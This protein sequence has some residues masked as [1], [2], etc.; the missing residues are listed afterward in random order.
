MSGPPSGL[1]PRRTTSPA[2]GHPV[3]AAAPREGDDATLI[4]DEGCIAH[5]AICH[6]IKVVDVSIDDGVDADE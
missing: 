6:I 2:P 5:I 3:A 1:R 4:I